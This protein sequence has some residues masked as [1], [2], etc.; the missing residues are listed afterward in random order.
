MAREL[1]ELFRVGRKSLAIGL[2][3]LAVCLATTQALAGRSDMGNLG[4][5]AQESFIILGWV[6]VWR[7]I[8][9]FLYDW[10]PIARHLSLI[11]DPR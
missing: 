8:E 3:V 10:W 2:A 9:I 1:D 5:I 4:R 11:I 7:P 6:A